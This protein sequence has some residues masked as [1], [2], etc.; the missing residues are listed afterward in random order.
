MF[1]RLKGAIDSR[2]AE[3][4]AR[5]QATTATPVS[6]SNSARRPTSRTASPSTR[7]RRA[8]PKE[9]DGA[10]AR[11]PDPSEFE[12]A[13]A[14]EDDSEDISNGVTPAT[15]EKPPTMTDTTVTPAD[16]A[17]GDVGDKG[18]ENAAATPPKPAGLPAEV[19]AKLRKLET[20]ESRYKDLL[21]SYRIAH[22]RAISIE[23]FEKALK[24]NTPLATI[25]D[26]D[27]LIEYVNQLNLKGDMVMDELKRVSADRDDYKKK[28]DES[29]KKALSAQNEL[30]ALK[31]ATQSDATTTGAHEKAETMSI[32]TPTAS[33]KSPVSSVLGIFSPKQKPQATSENKDVSEEFFSYDDEVPK[34]Q[35]EV[36]DKTAEIE[37]LKSKVDSL[38][39][40]LAVAQ[41][42]SSGLVESLEKATRELNESKEAAV[43]GQSRLKELEAQ[44]KELES[45]KQTLQ[46]KEKQ[47]ADL[48]T[49]L[50]NHKKESTEKI[51]LLE[52]DIA[53]QKKTA[54]GKLQS[55]IDA[56]KEAESARQMLDTQIKDLEKSRVGDTKRISELVESKKLLENQV[57][58]KTTQEVDGSEGKS[59]TPAS[60]PT[61]TTAGAATGAGGGKKK[62]RKKKKAGNAAAS[63]VKEAPVEKDQES[64]PSTPAT[65]DLQAEI[66]RLK[67]E[68]ADRDTQIAKLQT[69][70]KTEEDLREELEHMQD[71]FLNIGQE[72]VEAKDKIKELQTEKTALQERISKLEGEIETYKNQSKGADKVGA[73]FKSL[74]A[75]YEDL[76]L[77]SAT[78][79]TDLGAAQQLATSRYRDLTDLRDVLQQAQPELKTL[80][81]ENG[82]LKATKDELATR[83]ADLRRLEAR[84]KD[85]KSDVASFKKQAA[86]RENKIRELN[87]QVT[88]ETNGR[89]RAEDQV[90]VAQRDMRKSEAEKIKL[91]ASG[92][93]SASELEKVQEE[94]GKL[95]VKVRDL[96][97][98]VSK[99]TSE[100]KGLREEVELRGSQYNNA[101]GLLG[102]MRDQSSEMAMQLKEAKEQSESLEDEL[103]E[104]QK[105]LSERTREGET[106]RRLL[107]DVDDRAEAKIREMRERM[108]AAIEER[109]RAEDEA[110]TNG[111]RRAREV[112]ELKT[113]IRDF[114][115]DLK[116]AQ[117]DRDELQQ[118]EKEW[119][120][121]RDTLEGVSEKAAQEVNEIRSTMG[122][123][124]NALDGSEK[125]VREAEKQ[126]TDLRRLLEE[127]NQ[128]YEKL[129]KEFKT[130][131]AKQSRMNDVSSRSS[132]DSGRAG[133]PVNG[134]ARQQAGQMDYVY[135]KTI[136]LQFLE[137]KDK[138]R[139]ADL[140]KTVLGQLLRFD[141]KDQD[142]WMAAISAK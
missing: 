118:A 121:K 48:E 68:V 13:F 39:K 6:R 92:E 35:Q 115:R 20:L 41:E 30:E 113:K 101:Q 23:P 89:L 96:E 33:V 107:A 126:R 12:S 81:A 63:A 46:T 90:R 2:I 132:I 133:S 58:E 109:D 78:L 28:L 36:K 43:D 127:A 130:L 136:L 34:L 72:H 59:V 95:K 31:S 37:E 11:G 131:Q 104:I 26:P 94:A 51:A 1:Q 112:D 8:K 105:L 99:L 111:R 119:K 117:D 135:L 97:D 61:E 22:S 70:R 116:R 52:G 32:D 83:T 9:T 140:V 87:E 3:E 82:N 129:Q 77:K 139:Q 44:T 137:Q 142:K 103:A 16:N 67:D 38:G 7:P 62:N 50:A 21:R 60:Q 5:Q 79:Q 64:L 98:Q 56:R 124:R 4:Q 110:S 65:T 141:K 25:A 120:R 93:K 102:S 122:E 17:S 53:N 91:A 57:K 73:D 86:D 134:A 49:G 14:I 55:E 66:S 85:L 106:M 69:K 54:N 18:I 42:S 29:E 10:P 45:L 108:E 27:A 123:L 15:D 74:T 88:Q 75:E 114:E 100:S 76:K 71:N 40:D 138:K 47:L 125:Q 84:E 80:R 19:R 24:E 128:R